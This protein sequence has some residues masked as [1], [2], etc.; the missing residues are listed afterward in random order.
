MARDYNSRLQLT[1]RSLLAGGAAL[2]CAHA[3]P[4]DPSCT[5]TPE[6]EEGPYYID[7][8]RLR[9]DVTE[10]RPGVPLKLRVALVDSRRCAPLENVALDIWHCDALGVYSGF[11]ANSPDGPAGMPGRRG[12]PPG[13]GPGMPP[14]PGRG[15]GGPG[16]PDGPEGFGPPRA[17]QTDA[18]RFLRGVQLTNAKGIAEFASIYPGW[19]SGRAIHIHLKVHLG[20][21]AGDTYAGGHVSHTG[22]L[23]FPEDITQDVAKLQPYS[24][25]LQ[26]HRTLQSEDGI[27][28]GQ[29]GSATMLNLA[30]LTKGSNADG[31]LATV[32]LAIDPDAT[33]APVRGFGPGRGGRGA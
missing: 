30:R 6:Q 20:G 11:T 19:Y 13:F 18:S 10:G 15:P 14:P 5:L 8:A 24:K 12:G 25:R 31:F 22:Q 1:R 29:H 33:P 7:S 28:T 2:V 9:Q 21:S 32:T 17:Q 4:A 16:G 23:F 3:M 26:V 27:F